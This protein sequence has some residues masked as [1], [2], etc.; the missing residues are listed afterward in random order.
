MRSICFIT[1]KYPN[2]LDPNGLVFV[3]QLV[4]T[5]ADQGK[6]CT[7]ICPLAA[8]LRPKTLRI[9]NHIIETTERGNTID[10]YFPKYFGFGQSY[11]IFGKSPARMTTEA[12]T[13][14]VMNTIKRHNVEMNVVYGHFITPA[15]I[16][17]ARIGR[18]LQIPAFMAHGESTSWSID[19]YGA[20]KA[21]EELKSISGVIAVSSRNKQLLID[22]NVVTAD[23]IRVFPNG[24]RSERFYKHDKKE[25][26]KLFGW[27]DEDFIVGFCGSFD[28]R[29]GI[30][31][32]Q[33]AVDQIS[34]VKFACAGKGKLMPTSEKCI[35]AKPINHEELPWFYSAIDVFVLPT[36]NEGCCNAIVEAIACGCPIISSDRSFN[37]DICDITN[38]LLVD[39]DNIEQIRDSIITLKNNVAL[40]NYLAEGSLRIAKDLTLMQRAKNI[41]DFLDEKQ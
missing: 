29:K 32:L 17:A 7:V 23:K 19:Q 9:P 38:S 14:A 11:Y 6:K 40:C 15:G 33:E 36:R 34:D 28:E 18:K 13:L 22:A 5:I 39:P 35:W 41:V 4:W 31:R 24:Y 20:K 26:R 27:K 21:C 25:A 1:N 30:L 2:S 3:Q 16:A 37:I 12:F 10:V 8:N